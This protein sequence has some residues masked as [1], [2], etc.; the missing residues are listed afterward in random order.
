MWFDFL[1]TTLSLAG[2]VALA[3]IALAIANIGKE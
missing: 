1:Q 2:V 3:F